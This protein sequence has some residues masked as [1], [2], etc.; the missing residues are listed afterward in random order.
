MS[1]LARPGL[2]YYGL[3]KGNFVLLVIFLRVTLYQCV[4]WKHH[5]WLA[6]AFVLH[7]PSMTEKIFGAG[8]AYIRRFQRGSRSVLFPRH[9][10]EREKARKKDLFLYDFSVSHMAHYSVIWLDCQRSLNMIRDNLS[11]YCALQRD[12]REFIIDQ[13]TCNE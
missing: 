1:R 5:V 8:S 13:T 2:L 6:K 3:E 10:L 4:L 9:G 11:T 7:S 12:V